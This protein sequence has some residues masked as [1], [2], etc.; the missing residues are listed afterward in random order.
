MTPVQ[1]E[2]AEI[3]AAIAGRTVPDLLADMARD[4]PDEQAFCSESQTW[5]WSQAHGQVLGVAAALRSLGVGSGDVVALMASNRPEH[6]LADLGASA[7]GATTTTLYSTLA[8]EQIRHV[9]VDS[10]AKLA[11]VEGEDAWRRWG[12][13]LG[14]PAEL[15]ESA[16]RDE[17]A[18][19]GESGEQGESA[20][21]DVL[22]A[23]DVP[24]APAPA[25]FGGRVLDWQDFLELGAEPEAPG[26]RP[27]PGDTAVLIYTSGTTGRSKGVRLSHRALLYEVEALARVAGLPD[28][29]VSLSYLPLAHVAERVLSVYLPLRCGGRTH[30]C[31]SVKE[32]PQRLPQVR[33][34]IFFGV[35]QVWEKLRAGIESKLAEQGGL[36]ARLG[37]WALRAGT[38]GAEPDAT[39]GRKALARLADRAVLHRIP[40]ALGLDRCAVRAVGAAP[41]PPGLERFFAG[42]G[43]GLTGVYGLSETCGAA[44]MHR[45]DADRSGTVG[46]AMPG[47]E[48]ELAEDGEVLLRG[49]LCT[50]G[51]RNLPEATADLFTVDGWLRTG[52]LGRLTADGQLKITGRKKEVI[53][54]A[55]GKNISPVAVES[56]LVEHPLV[57]QAMVHGDD[58]PHLVA[59]LMPDP[60][61]LAR[62]AGAR[63][64]AAAGREQLLTDPRLRAEFAGAVRAA[65]AKLARVEHV[66]SWGLA[67]DEWTEEAGELTPTRKIRRKVLTEHHR[68]QLDGLYQA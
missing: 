43:L 64:L 24:G 51:Y 20:E 17:S 49:P 60:D 11:V 10:G 9:L 1:A 38:A 7:A 44:V 48:L 5:T 57:G 54:T 16:E 67:A 18:E 4:R 31:A 66:R 36:R 40:A 45:A 63:G 22:V 25:G 41:L 32:L 29:V 53:V 65:N 15:G 8:P 21:L 39:R 37:R 12:A 33:P 61:E 14:E 46:S 68:E 42:I 3:E 55:G 50:S 27:D 30:F 56:L 58:R 19:Q 52:D 13:V 2:R 35:P 23:L 59:L 47:V 26:D 34:T 28:Q 62:W 6:V